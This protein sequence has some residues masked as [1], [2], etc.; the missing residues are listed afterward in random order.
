MQWL[1]IDS[2]GPWVVSLGTNGRGP[3]GVSG[4]RLSAF[5]QPR[6]STTKGKVT[7]MASILIADDD[8]DTRE[9]LALAVSLAGH[10][11]LRARDGLAA[12]TSALRHQ[13]D[14]LVLDCLMPHLS[15]FD[16]CSRLR[17]HPPFQSTPIVLITGLESRFDEMQGFLAGATDYIRKPFTMTSLR[18]RIEKALN[19]SEAPNAINRAQQVRAPAS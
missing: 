7:D 4:S 5:D 17:R 11:V 10:S 2:T 9:L 12:I 16:V 13:P 1:R 18:T 15:G 6:T 3:A 14:L 19:G 8:D